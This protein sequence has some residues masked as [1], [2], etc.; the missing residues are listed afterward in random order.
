MIQCT[1]RLPT[2][3]FFAGGVGRCPLSNE[4]AYFS[5]EDTKFFAFSVAISVDSEAREQVLNPYTVNTR[6]TLKLGYD[7][8]DPGLLIDGT[9]SDKMVVLY[10]SFST[11]SS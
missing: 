4:D 2:K 7:N 8:G 10:L 5:F 11:S 9:S 6:S 3:Y 1:T